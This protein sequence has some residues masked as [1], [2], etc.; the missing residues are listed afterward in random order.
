MTDDFGVEDD[1]QSTKIGGHIRIYIH[2]KTEKPHQN[3]IAI[4]HKPWRLS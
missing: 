4:F 3:K 1:E 2:H